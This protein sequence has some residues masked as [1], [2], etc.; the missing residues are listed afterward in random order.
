M[1]HLPFFGNGTPL[2]T[3]SPAAV[4]LLLER[5]IK[6]AIP[7]DIPGKSSQGFLD[8]GDDRTQRFHIGHVVLILHMG[9]DQPIVILGEGNDG[10]ELTGGMT[11]ALLDDSNPGFMERIDP[12]PGS[13][14]TA[15]QKLHLML[16]TGYVC[17]TANNG[18][19]LLVFMKMGLNSG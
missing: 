11:L 7:G 10:A 19:I 1:W 9:K 12:M 5:L 14:D 4:L 2:Y 6:P 13:W 18:L 3:P 16:S 17:P 8:S 15:M